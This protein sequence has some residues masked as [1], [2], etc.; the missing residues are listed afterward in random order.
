MGGTANES[1]VKYLQIID[2]MFDKI[3]VVDDYESEYNDIIKHRGANYKFSYGDYIVK[4]LIG[5]LDREKDK[6]DE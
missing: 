6:R 5:S 3:D 4:I 1:A 2:E